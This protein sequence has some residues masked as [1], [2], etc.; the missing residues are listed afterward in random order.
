MQETETH[1]I[2]QS[3]DQTMPFL[4]SEKSDS[5]IQTIITESSNCRTKEAL[6]RHLKE[7]G[8]L[9][10]AQSYFLKDKAPLLTSESGTEIEKENNQ[11]NDQTT[12]II[13]TKILKRDNTK[14]K[15]NQPDIQIE[16]I[17]NDSMDLDSSELSFPYKESI[18]LVSP[19]QNIKDDKIKD[20]NSEDET[21]K[22]YTLLRNHYDSINSIAFHPY[23]KTFL[24]GSADHTVKFWKFDF[25]NEGF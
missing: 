20:G 15:Q 13:V 16:D 4:E 23:E 1:D 5:S 11:L 19:I 7:A 17:K 2:P 10:S 25:S 9:L 8:I 14:E 3:Q 24:T 18:D 21:W 22:N 12:P 6:K